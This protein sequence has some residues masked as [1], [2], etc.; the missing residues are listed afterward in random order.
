MWK[1]SVRQTFCEVFNTET[2]STVKHICEA[3][4]DTGQS[5][6]KDLAISRVTLG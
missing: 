5:K 1:H 4:H 2:T 6:C 3:G